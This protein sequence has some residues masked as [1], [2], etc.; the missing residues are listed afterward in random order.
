MA[1]SFQKQKVM[2]GG[3]YRVFRIIEDEIATMRNGYRVFAQTCLGEVLKSRDDN[4]HRSINS[5]RADILVID[6]GGWPVLAVE[7]QGDGHYQGTAA[8]RDAVKKEALRKAGVQYLEVHPTDCDDEIRSRLHA[9]LG[10]RSVR[11]KT[12]ATL[13]RT[14]GAEHDERFPARARPAE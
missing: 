5:K 4:A 10:L 13:P 6:R 11:Q 3:E 2:N 1:A 7:Y 12:P 9:Q 14:A 8:A